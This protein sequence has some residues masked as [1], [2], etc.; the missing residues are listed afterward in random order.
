MAQNK[1][2]SGDARGIQL[3][4]L[5]QPDH[6]AALSD[7]TER[8]MRDD[9]ELDRR[10]LLDAPDHFGRET[11]AS[12]VSTMDIWTL[13]C[14]LAALA[15]AVTTVASDHLAWRL[16]YVHQLQVIGFLLSIMGFCLSNVLS[17]LFLRCEARFG[18][19][20]IQDYEAIMRNKPFASKVD[21]PWRA[22]L[23]IL[24][25]LPLGLSVA[26]KRFTGGAAIERVKQNHELYSDQWGMFAP[27]GLLPLGWNSGT[28]LMYNATT[29]FLKA[30]TNQS[31]TTDSQY[32]SLAS[33]LPFPAT[34]PSPYGFNTLLINKTAVAVL[35]APPSDWITNVQRQLSLGESWSITATV[36]ATVSASDDAVDSH[37]NETQDSVFWS[38]F[39]GVLQTQNLFDGW[40]L[41]FLK[42]EQDK[43]CFVA[44][45]SSNQTFAQAASMWNTVRQS[46]HGTWRITQGDVQLIEADC[47][48]DLEDPDPS[49]NQQLVFTQNILALPDYYMPI[50]NEFLAQFHPNRI[51]SEW[52]MPTIAMVVANMYWSRVTAMNGPESPHWFGTN[53]FG[54]G[55][56]PRYNHTVTNA[57]L[58]YTS[59]S[60]IYSSRPSMRRSRWLYVALA[61]QPV[62]AFLAVLTSMAT[63]GVPV[64]KGFGLVAILAGIEKGS[65][66][67]LAGAGY[68]G[69]L[70]RRIYLN[71]GVQEMK[72]A[73]DKLSYWLETGRRTA[74]E[75]IS[76]SRSYC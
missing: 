32:A 1:S 5:E 49:D 35:D 71:V 16:G 65:L 7:L 3:S 39:Y 31:A 37:R 72:G 33:D 59:S 61:A 46:C 69:E 41:G 44:L 27:P 45:Q 24:S 11:A 14:S 22:T 12:V 18:R 60:T 54:Y 15:L 48:A 17:T 38:P 9:S 19:S 76:L 55:L 52:L 40:N 74:S 25:A 29:P 34:T 28:I 75:S 8:G 56:A 2:V 10:R 67:L 57:G 6:M 36:L 23:L 66:S 68:S 4:V 64:G 53:S 20:T 58:L 63:H 43:W 73:S 30:S 62:M 21:W 50:L 42:H 47:A 70:T 26:Y 51:D 13:V